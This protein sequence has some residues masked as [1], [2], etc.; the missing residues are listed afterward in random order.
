MEEKKNEKELQ[1]KYAKNKS[2][3]Y[4]PTVGEFG[5]CCEAE[6]VAIIYNYIRQSKWGNYD[7]FEKNFTMHY[8]YEASLLTDEKMHELF[9]KYNDVDTIQKIRKERMD[10]IHSELPKE[11]IE[12]LKTYRLRVVRADGR[13]TSHQ[14]I[15]CRRKKSYDK[16]R[17]SGYQLMKL[18][19]GTVIAG[20]K[21]ELYESD[22]MDFISKLQSGEIKI[23]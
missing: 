5:F 13:G 23:K 8:P 18:N 14:V 4:N 19:C 9:E 17:L 1:K 20:K 22:V 6:K 10:R 3:Y 7:L 21:F 2:K 15:K 11:V 16:G 12:V